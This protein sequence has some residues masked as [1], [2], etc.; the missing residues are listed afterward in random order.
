[1][2]SI[3]GVPCVTEL[4]IEKLG[5]TSL[6]TSELPVAVD[7]RIELFP[8]GVWADYLAI[9][10]GSAGWEEVLA[11]WDP[12]LIVA[13]DPAFAE[14]LIDVGWTE[15]YADEDGILLARPSQ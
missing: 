1:M 3:G 7:S 10:Q 12:Q 8:T 11:T 2:L 15:R 13:S 5:N 6:V 14:R 9:T 4:P